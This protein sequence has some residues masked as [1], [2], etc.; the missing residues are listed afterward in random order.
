MYM[1]LYTLMFGES[2]YEYKH[3]DDNSLY[4]CTRLSNLGYSHGQVSV[5]LGVKVQ[6]SVV[7]GVKVQVSVVLGV[8][9]QVSVVLEVKVQVSVVLGVKV[10]IQQNSSM[11][12]S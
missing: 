7:L 9:V 10:Q 8:K 6:V 5:V 3:W 2:L 1:Q 11:D 12:N 4:H